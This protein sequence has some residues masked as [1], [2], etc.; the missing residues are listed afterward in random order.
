M[1]DFW[2]HNIADKARRIARY[3][4]AHRLEL[5]DDIPRKPRRKVELVSPAPGASRQRRKRRIAAHWRL[6]QHRTR[7]TWPCRMPFQILQVAHAPVS[8]LPPTTLCG[9]RAGGEQLAG[10][11]HRSPATVL[12]TPRCQCYPPYRRRSSA[13]GAGNLD[14]EFEIQDS[15]GWGAFRRWGDLGGVSGLRPLGG[16]GCGQQSDDCCY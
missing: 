3:G 8:I 16:F 15:R 13:E 5:L 12:A 7:Y 6:I 9:Q 1:A 11:V 4:P 14:L 10:G 2:Q